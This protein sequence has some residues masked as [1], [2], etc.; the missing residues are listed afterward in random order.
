MNPPDTDLLRQFIATRD[1]AAFHELTRRYFDTVIGAA[2]RRTNGDR[3]LAEDIAQIVFIDFARQAKAL[4]SGVPLGGWLHRHTCFVAS[5]AVRT[6][7]RRRE[8]ESTA[9]TLHEPQATMQNTPI[10]PLAAALDESLLELSETDRQALVLRFLERRDLRSVGSSL[11]IS[12]D[13]AQKRVSR[14]LEK[15]R[16]LLERRGVRPAA[17]ASGLAALLAPESAEAAAPELIQQVARRSSAAAGAAPRLAYSWAAWSSVAL[18]VVLVGAAVQRWTAPVAPAPVSIAPQ[19]P[20]IATPLAKQTLPL[21]TPPAVDTGLADRL[22]S[23]TRFNMGSDD[24]LAEAR[25]LVR[26]LSAQELEALLSLV[27]SRPIDWRLRG[28]AATLILNAWARLEPEMA[29]QKAEG[30]VTQANVLLAWMKRDRPAALAWLEA[31]VKDEGLSKRTTQLTLAATERL[32]GQGELATAT[33]LAA[34]LA[35]P[36]NASDIFGQMTRLLT[37]AKQREVMRDEISRLPDAITREQALRGFVASWANADREGARR[38]IEAQPAEARDGLVAAFARVWMWVDPAAEAD[39]WVAQS[40][41]KEE[42]IRSAMEGWRPEK[43]NEAAAWLQR[44]GLGPKADAGLAAF[45]RSAL[46]QDP[47]AALTWSAVISEPELRVRTSRQLF[48]TWLDHDPAGAASF[49]QSA[50]APAATKAELQ[51]LVPNLP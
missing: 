21:I 25:S 11:G 4:P 9:A 1:E 42:A 8:R 17:V 33:A 22:I 40:S 2:M 48:Q 34:R 49:I 29:M 31:Q 3:T 14:A 15:L 47:A 26:E 37:D 30:E 20:V 28:P 32:A 36:G 7:I 6:E 23:L 35:Q 10:S 39:W 13:T 50:S 41:R 27:G 51:T 46:V 45:A 24:E 19:V 44:Q 43:I 18:G 5:K 38:W 16:G 12:E